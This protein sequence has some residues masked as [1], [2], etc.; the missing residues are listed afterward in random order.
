MGSWKPHKWGGERGQRLYVRLTYAKHQWKY[1]RLLKMAI[2]ESNIP[3]MVEL[4][5]WAIL[6]ASF[7]K[8]I[9]NQYEVLCV[10]L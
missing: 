8:N 9:E 4:S 6:P 2:R 7:H 10:S 1:Y 5:D 3:I